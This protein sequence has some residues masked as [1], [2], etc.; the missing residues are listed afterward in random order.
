MKLLRPIP[1]P[2]IE[3]SLENIENVMEQDATMCMC[4]NCKKPTCG[5]CSAGISQIT[6]IKCKGC[7]IP[8]FEGLS[9]GKQEKRLLKMTR[10]DAR[11]QTI[12]S[13][14]SFKADQ[15][16]P[17]FFTRKGINAKPNG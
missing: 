2:S 4:I 1:L 17:T 14:I 3:I 12:Q 8:V 7:L 9:F 13:E 16:E 5:T 10:H 11:T 6:H 15:C